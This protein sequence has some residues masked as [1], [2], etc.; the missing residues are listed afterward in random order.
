MDPTIVLVH[1]AYAGSSS[2]QGA[3]PELDTIGRQ[4]IA[5]A[6]PLRGLASDAALLS[7]LVAS[8]DGPVMLVGHSYGG[9]VMTAV[10]PD[11]GDVR[12]LVFVAGFALEQGESA[13]AASG[14]AP[15]STLLDTL[16]RVPLAAGGT[17]TYI[18]QEKYHR[19]FCADLA[20]E[21]AHTLAVTQRP[22]TEEALTEP[23]TGTPLWRATPSWFIFG[24]ADHNIPV[25]AHR[26]MAERAGARRT[27]EVPGSSHVV[28]ISHVK[29]TTDLVR[30]AATDVRS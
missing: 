1:G 24:E 4:V 8:I 29:E 28:G 21:Q 26:I 23:L 25:G 22:I 30:E 6:N 27:V 17:D 18:A 19:Q 2:W 3:L 9:A 14:L 5:F 7:D 13:A 15:G 12:A 20:A 11:A 16:E 10:R